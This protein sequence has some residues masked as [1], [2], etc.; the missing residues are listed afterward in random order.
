MF[1]YL[2]AIVSYL[3]IAVP[4]FSGVYDDKNASE[5]AQIISETAFVCMYLVYQV[6]SLQLTSSPHPDLL[7][8]ALRQRHQQGRQSGRLHAQSSRAH[9]EADTPEQEPQGGDRGVPAD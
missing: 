1:Q 8:G 3:V 2:G 6:M 7:A 5:L 4:I 9:R